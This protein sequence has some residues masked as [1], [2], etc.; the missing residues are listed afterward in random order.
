MGIEENAFKDWLK[1]LTQLEDIEVQKAWEKYLTDGFVA[2]LDSS[3][4]KKIKKLFPESSIN[5]E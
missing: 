4:K 1:E 2:S 3:L 5:L